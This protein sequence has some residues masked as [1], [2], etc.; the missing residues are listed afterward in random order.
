M[1]F[2]EFINSSCNT[3]LFLFRENPRNF[4]NS[5]NNIFTEAFYDHEMRVNNRKTLY[6]HID[7]LEAYSI[8]YKNIG[9][10]NH[11]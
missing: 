10:N 5:R 9:I 2:L 11:Y 4:F 3:C 8:D 1:I 7:E 6:I